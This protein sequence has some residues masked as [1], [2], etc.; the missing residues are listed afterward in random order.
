MQHIDA[1]VEREWR[2]QTRAV[3]I[4]QARRAGQIAERGQDHQHD[5]FA[6]ETRAMAATG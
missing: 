2:W 3:E 6:R 4:V 5:Q 1:Q